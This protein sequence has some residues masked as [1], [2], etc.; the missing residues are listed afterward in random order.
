[1]FNVYILLKSFTN[2]IVKGIFMNNAN[3]LLIK[4]ISLIRVKSRKL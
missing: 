1:M 2:I 3:F 4:H